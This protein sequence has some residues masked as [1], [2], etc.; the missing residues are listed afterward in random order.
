LLEL[1]EEYF[2]KRKPSASGSRS[3]VG[4]EDKD[5]DTQYHSIAEN[6][7]NYRSSSQP[8]KDFLN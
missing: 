7:L 6:Y 4:E 1:D 2:N 8:N 3:K 5:D